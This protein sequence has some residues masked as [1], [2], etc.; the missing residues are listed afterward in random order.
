[1][2]AV[3]PGDAALISASVEP[4]VASTPAAV[5]NVART[6][7]RAATSASSAAAISG[8][9]PKART[10]ASSPRSSAASAR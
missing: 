2:G 10:A 3:A 5:A 6:P 7:R 4:P 8:A 9:G 1:M